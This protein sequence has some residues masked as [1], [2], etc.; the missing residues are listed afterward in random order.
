MMLY[1]L[2]SVDIS[3]QF[4]IKLFVGNGC[5]N[6]GIMKMGADNVFK[7]LCPPKYGGPLCEGKNKLVVKY[8]FTFL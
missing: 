6:G 5:K 4:N 7:C 8:Y 1:Y 2:T 3:N